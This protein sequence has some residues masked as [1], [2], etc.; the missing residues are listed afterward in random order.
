MLTKNQLKI[1][2]LLVSQPER[3]YYLS[4]IGEILGKKPGV[5]QRGI[6]SL[7]EQGIIV[8]RRRS[9]LRLF[10]INQDYP[11]FQEL[12]KIIEKTVGVEGLLR[13]LVNGLEE[14]EIAFI[15][16]S[17]AKSIMRVDSDIDLAIVGKS[18]AEAKL[19][20]E[21]RTIEKNLDRDINYRLYTKKEFLEKRESHDAFLEEILSDKC[22]LLKGDVNV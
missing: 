1:L 7:E 21:I 12:K 5:F 8:S 4:E 18:S 20:K 3:E 15:Y 17:Y 6:N 2:A 9:N 14:I 13:E 10:K 16:G 19:L 22:V 11:L